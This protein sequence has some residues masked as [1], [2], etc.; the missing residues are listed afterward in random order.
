MEL[1][2]IECAQHEGAADLQDHG[3]ADLAEALG[4]DG[5]CILVNL[6]E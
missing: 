2:C 4:E 3:H 6:R 5:T 1:H